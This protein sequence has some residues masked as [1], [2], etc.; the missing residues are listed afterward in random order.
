MRRTILKLKPVLQIQGDKLDAFAKARTISQAK[1]IMISAIKKDIE[2]RF[3]GSSRDVPIY[4]K[5]R[6]MKRIVDGE[7][8]EGILISFHEQE[9]PLVPYFQ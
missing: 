2:E 5:V 3:G 6:L 4:I 1:S 8:V 9:Y 7:M